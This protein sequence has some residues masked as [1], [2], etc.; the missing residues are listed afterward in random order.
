M[1]G[2]CRLAPS[3]QCGRED[4]I[5]VSV[6]TDWNIEG[7]RLLERERLPKQSQ[8][9]PHVGRALT[10]LALEDVARLVQ[11]GCEEMTMCSRTQCSSGSWQVPTAVAASR[12]VCWPW[13]NAS[14]MT[15][16]STRCGMTSNARARSLWSGVVMDSPVP[17]GR[18]SDRPVCQNP[19]Q[20]RPASRRWRLQN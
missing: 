1:E 15:S 14:F 6:S 7:A 17:N 10:E 19:L 5:V 13:F 2:G 9:T 20:N 18:S 11:Q 8:S 3:G 4:H 12:V 16:A